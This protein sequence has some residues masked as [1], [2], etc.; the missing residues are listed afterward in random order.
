MVERFPQA[1]LFDTAAESLKGRGSFSYELAPND[2]ANIARGVIEA[3][4][5]I[6]VSKVQANVR[7]G[8]GYI[9]LTVKKLGHLSDVTV[10]LGNGGAPNTLE[11]VGVN[12]HSTHMV[13]R[14]TA[15]S[16]AKQNIAN[17]FA[18]PTAVFIRYFAK[19]FTARGASFNQIKTLAFRGGKLA[20][21]VAHDPSAP[22][23]ADA[24]PLSSEK[25]HFFKEAIKG[26]LTKRRAELKTT[27]KSFGE[28]ALTVGEKGAQFLQKFFAFPQKFNQLLIDE[29]LVGYS[30]GFL[31]F[32]T[33]YGA[34]VFGTSTLISATATALGLGV[35][36]KTLF[37]SAQEKKKRNTPTKYGGR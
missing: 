32:V 2:F 3:I 37:L 1:S 28:H 7:D 18:N 12:T 29:P 31:L 22:P 26:Y 25:K 8:R 11:L 36:F 23:L 4:P 35:W 30:V 20:I 14:G 24:A 10:V 17:A 16:E 33:G 27:M 19:Q 6:K 15:G 9:T 21:E 5:A 13:F 34:A